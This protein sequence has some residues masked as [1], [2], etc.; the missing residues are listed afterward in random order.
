MRFDRNPATTETL[1]RGP[2][3]IAAAE[4]IQNQIARFGQ[5]VNEK[6]SKANGHSSRVQFNFMH[7]A[8]I[9]II[10]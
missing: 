2:G 5:K 4:R 7:T 6:L 9:L 1:S 3:R 8:K 10:T